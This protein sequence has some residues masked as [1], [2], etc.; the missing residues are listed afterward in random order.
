MNRIKHLIKKPYFVITIVYV[1]AHGFLL[2]LNGCWWDDWTFM[3]HNLIYINQVAF[4][5]GRPEWNILIPLCWSLPNN[6]RILIFV[7][8]YFISIFVY[9]ILNDST[10]FNKKECLTITLL[11]TVLPVNESR[12]LISNFPYSVGLF[13]FYLTFMLFIKWNTKTKNIYV[14]ALLVFLFFCS[15]ILTSLLAYY[16]VIFI[17]L[18]AYDMLSNKN[19]GIK[20]FLITIKRLIIK[21]FNFFDLPFILLLTNKLHQTANTSKKQTLLL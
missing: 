7:L 20:Q 14:R 13:L 12:L 3:D 19:I 6:G 15:F 21:Y 18:I 8:Y 11:F 17:Y 9:N 10:F 2:I 1:L 5:S 4:Q 16:Y